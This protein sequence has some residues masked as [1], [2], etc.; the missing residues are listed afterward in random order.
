MY[1]L[2]KTANFIG[3]IHYVHE[4]GLEIH[5]NCEKSNYCRHHCDFTLVSYGREAISL[6]Y[7]QHDGAVLVSKVFAL[8]WLR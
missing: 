7:W 1:D 2:V 5:R 8:C 3:I 6:Q 4:T